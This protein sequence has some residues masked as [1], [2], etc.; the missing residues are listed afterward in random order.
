MTTQA[1]MII[2]VMVIAV[3]TAFCL[4]MWTIIAR[5][6]AVAGMWVMLVGI[7]LLLVWFGGRNGR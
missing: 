1:R 6:P 7:V 3:V 2:S 4:P 5:D